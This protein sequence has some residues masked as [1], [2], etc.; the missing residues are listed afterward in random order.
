MARI[1]ANV[2][3]GNSTHSRGNYMNVK[4]LIELLSKEDQ[5]QEVYFSHD[6]HDY[7]GTTLAS[8]VTSIEETDIQYT[9]YHECFSAPK[10]DN[11][12]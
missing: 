1:L 4:T 5:E 9:S 7:W 10:P 6:S 11:N 12:I 8:K 3:R 2:Y